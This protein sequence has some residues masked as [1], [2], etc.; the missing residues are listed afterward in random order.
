MY[1]QTEQHP[2]TVTVHIVYTPMLESAAF[3]ALRQTLDTQGWTAVAQPTRPDSLQEHVYLTRRGTGPNGT[4]TATEQ[5][6]WGTDI[7]QMLERLVG[8]AIPRITA[9]PSLPPPVPAPVIAP[10]AVTAPVADTPRR[11]V[12]RTA[13]RY[14][15]PRAARQPTSSRAP[16]M[17]SEPAAEPLSPTDRLKRRFAPQIKLHRISPALADPADR[18]R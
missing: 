17:T 6:H 8:R 4:W 3:R 13:L 2:T 11:I 1:I 12:D 14:T 16:V 18:A 5:S 15:R 10:A 9:A 7:Q